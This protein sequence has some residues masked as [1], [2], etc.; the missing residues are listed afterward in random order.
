MNWISIK[1]KLP[2]E[3]SY[4]VA[5]LFDEPFFGTT[6]SGN[7]GAAYY[8]HESGKWISPITGGRLITIEVHNVT[9][10]MPLPEPPN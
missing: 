9:H 6:T 10:W 8:D 3:G 5:I 1:D 2:E 4:T 7:K